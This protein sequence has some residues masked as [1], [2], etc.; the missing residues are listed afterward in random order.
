MAIAFE[1]VAT[2]TRDTDGGVLVI[3]KP[4]GTVEGDVLVAAV[5]VDGRGLISGPAGWTKEIANDAQ[6]LGVRAGLAVFWLVAG[7]SEPATY[8][9]TNTRNETATGAIARYSGVDTAAT[10]EASAKADG[11]SLTPVTPSVTTLGA[12]RM[13][14]RAVAMDGD[15]APFTP[16]GGHSERYD[17]F[18][19]PGG[20]PC[21]GTGADALQAS[22][23]ASGTGTFTASSSAEWWAGTLALIPGAVAAAA[24]SGMV[25]ARVADYVED[26]GAGSLLGN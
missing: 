1:T 14:V 10:V 11:S 13:I 21:S 23:G 26:W 15:R 2:A 3:D 25:A 5:G 9:F 12:D 16:P 19:V 4:V 17:L 6:D 22:G 18:T 8:T 24:G 20:S 7:A